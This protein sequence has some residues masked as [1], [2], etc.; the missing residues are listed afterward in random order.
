MNRKNN[1]EIKKDIQT[2][3]IREF[4]DWRGKYEEQFG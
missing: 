1:K 3:T 2:N 4:V